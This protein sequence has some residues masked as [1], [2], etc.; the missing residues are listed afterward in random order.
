M[1]CFY[2]LSRMPPAYVASRRLRRTSVPGILL[3]A[4]D[5]RVGGGLRAFFILFF[6]HS[7]ESGNPDC[8]VPRFIL[9]VLNVT[10]LEE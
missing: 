4:P 1:M 3:N 5:L 8:L 9:G 7:R 2:L 6:G 10:M